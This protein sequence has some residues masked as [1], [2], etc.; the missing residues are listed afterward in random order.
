MQIGQ[1]L[2]LIIVH[3]L[4]SF[5]GAIF[6]LGQLSITNNMLGIIF[7]EYGKNNRTVAKHFAIFYQLR[8]SQIAAED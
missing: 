4:L 7:P 8:R 3:H 6:Q 5:Q 1:I 2:V